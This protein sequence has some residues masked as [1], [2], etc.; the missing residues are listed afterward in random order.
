[1]SLN[2][3]KGTHYSSFAFKLFVLLLIFLGICIMLT[4]IWMVLMMFFET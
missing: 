2:S 3:N 1:M 4:P